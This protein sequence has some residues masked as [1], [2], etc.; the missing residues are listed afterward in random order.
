MGDGEVFVE[1]NALLGQPCQIRY[2]NVSQETQVRLEVRRTVRG[3]RAVVGVLQP[4]DDEA[5]ERFSW[6]LAGSAQGLGGRGTRGDISRRG[7]GVLARSQS[8]EGK[9]SHTEGGEDHRDDEKDQTAMW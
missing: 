3:R 4:D 2:N 9:G 6:H 8:S 5:I 7:G 1:G